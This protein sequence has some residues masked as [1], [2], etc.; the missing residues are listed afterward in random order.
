MEK[1]MKIIKDKQLL[2]HYIKKYDIMNLFTDESIKEHMELRKYNKRE[3]IVSPEGI[4]DEFLIMVE[5]R[6][7]V[8]S[9][10]SNGKVILISFYKP[11]GVLGDVEYALGKETDYIVEALT[12]ATYIAIDRDVLIKKTETD[13]KFKNY[14]MYSLAKKLNQSAGKNMFN[15]LYPLENRIASYILSICKKEADGT[16]EDEVEIYNLKDAAQFLGSSYRHLIRTLN[17]L[18]ENGSIDRNRNTIKIKDRK[19]LELLAEELYEWG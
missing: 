7:K 17:S 10:S 5:G 14:I 15:L 2:E 13:I 3:Y 6:A 12:D 19:S 11:F 1:K 8:Y 9:H 18:E 16:P 4:L